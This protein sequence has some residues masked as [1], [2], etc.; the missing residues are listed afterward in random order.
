MQAC[1]ALS[2]ANCKIKSHPLDLT[3]EIDSY[4]YVSCF[5]HDLVD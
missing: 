4:E 5:D 2:F 3:N 1:V